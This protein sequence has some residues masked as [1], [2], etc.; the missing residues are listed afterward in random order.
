MDL[1]RT[2]VLAIAK[3]HKR[4]PGQVVLKWNLQSGNI[5][6]PKSCSEKRIISNFDLFDFK[7]SPEEMK[8]MDTMDKNLRTCDTKEYW[9]G[10]AV[11]AN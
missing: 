7:L 9:G 11:F 1:H 8:K 5:I 2:Q 3:S 4:D 10:F 6:I